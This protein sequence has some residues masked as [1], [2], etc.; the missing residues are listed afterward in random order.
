M[1]LQRT[2][3]YRATRILSWVLPVVIFVFLGI[4]AWSYWV[5]T[6][7]AQPR[8]ATSDELPTGV[9]V[10]TNDVQYVVSVS[11][12]DQFQVRAK[13]MLVSKDN[14]S[15]LTGVEVFIYAQK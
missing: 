14:R 11:G 15:L 13:Q 4:A 8:V 2:A 7:N 5:R 10:R 12:K 9:A 6:H 1:R 3:V